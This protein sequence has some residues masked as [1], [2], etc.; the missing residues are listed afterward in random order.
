MVKKWS[1]ERD[2]TKI[3]FYHKEKNFPFLITNLENIFTHRKDNEKCN[4]VTYEL[5][6]NII[7]ASTLHYAYLHVI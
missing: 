5:I 3:I 2:K 6:L 1:K 4:I 7:K